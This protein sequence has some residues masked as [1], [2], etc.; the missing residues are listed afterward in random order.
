MPIPNIDTPVINILR[1]CKNK[2]NGKA[3][4]YLKKF[5]Y[6]VCII[7]THVGLLRRFKLVLL[8]CIGVFYFFT[9]LKN[10]KD[11]NTNYILMQ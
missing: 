9:V 6:Y 11:H 7:R 1:K 10:L 3:K 8:S 4:N 5:T 2:D